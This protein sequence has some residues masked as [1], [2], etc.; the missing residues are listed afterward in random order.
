MSY[1]RGDYYVWHDGDNV[2]LWAANGYDDWDNAVWACDLE[3]NRHPDRSNA[4]GIAIAE[5]VLDQFV[6]MRLAEM[7][8]ENLVD[9]AIDRALENY[10][11]NFGCY[12]LAQNAAQLKACLKQIQHV[13]PDSAG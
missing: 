6:M 10:K 7:I 2:H 13:K 4:S 11:G 9:D 5:A 8:E 12:A 1:M 3:G